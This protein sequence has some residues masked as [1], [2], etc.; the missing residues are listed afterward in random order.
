MCG[1]RGYAAAGVTD[2]LLLQG[3][4]RRKGGLMTTE[5]AVMRTSVARAVRGYMSPI[6]SVQFSLHEYRQKPRQAFGL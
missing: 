5:S 4:K 2:G 6:R 3:V 1:D